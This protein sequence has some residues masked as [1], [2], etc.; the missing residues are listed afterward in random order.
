M[1]EAILP[2]PPTA[3]AAANLAPEERTE[4]QKQRSRELEAR[5]V[6]QSFLERYGSFSNQGNFENISDLE[7]LMTVNMKKVAANYVREQKSLYP[8]EKGYY[9]ITT[10]AL[11]SALSAMSESRVIVTIGTQR[12]ESA[13]SSETPRILYQEATLQ[14]VKIGSVWKIDDVSWG[15]VK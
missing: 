1:P 4:I 15:S 7:P 14:L 8:A 11:T 6:A 12:Q 9:G 5:R 2:A 10:R 13:G 3:P